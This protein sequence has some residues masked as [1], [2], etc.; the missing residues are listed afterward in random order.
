MVAQVC[1]PGTQEAEGK[2]VEPS[3]DLVL[4]P[5]KLCDE[6]PTWIL[7]MGNYLRGF[8]CDKPHPA[9]PAQRTEKKNLHAVLYFVLHSAR[10]LCIVG[11]FFGPPTHQKTKQNKDTETY[12]N[13]ESSTHNL[14]LFLIY[15]LAPIT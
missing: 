2:L 6:F 9:V 12:I 3:G 7:L 14:G 11:F 15:S 5:T 8:F 10:W 4:S 1:H 13:S